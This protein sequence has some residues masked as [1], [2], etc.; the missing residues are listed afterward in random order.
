MS[1]WVCGRCK[2]INRERAA[3][4]YSCGGVRG[5]IQLQP[6]SGSAPLPSS[7]VGTTAAAAATAGAGD[8]PPVLTS[9]IPIAEVASPTPVS[10]EPAGLGDLAGGVV[11]GAIGAVLASALWYAVVVITNWQIGLIAIAVGFIVGQGVV[12]GAGRRPSILLVPISVAFTAV[13]LI[14]SE[15]FIASH[16]YNIAAA[17]IAAEMGLTVAEV[18]GLVQLSPVELVR[19]SI[20][21][22]MITLVFW[23]IAAYEAFAIPM[24]AVTRSR[25]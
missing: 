7:A 13:A 6:A 19:L 22:D 23:A 25:D 1:D 14:V 9:G 16:F 12:L 11:G 17:E 18:T 2:S 3:T 20:E 15:Y 8:A 10:T 4:C 5:A 21:S 24:G